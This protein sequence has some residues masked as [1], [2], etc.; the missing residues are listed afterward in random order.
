M[1]CPVKICIFSYL[2]NI[3]GGVKHPSDSSTPG[4]KSMDEPEFEYDDETG[5]D[6]EANTGEL[7]FRSLLYLEFVWSVN[8]AFKFNSLEA[9]LL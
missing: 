6:L 2:L 8:E 9:L 5:L 3:L 1:C 4:W 7:N